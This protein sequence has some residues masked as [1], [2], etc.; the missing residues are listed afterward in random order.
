MVVRFDGEGLEPALVKMARRM[1]MPVV[2]VD[3]GVFEPVHES[4]HLAILVGQKDEMK[5]VGHEAIAKE[6]NG[7][8]FVGIAQSF[9]ESLV[10][11]VLEEN[12]SAHIATVDHVIT[13][14]AYIRPS[15]ARHGS[16]V[17]GRPEDFKRKDECPLFFSFLARTS[18]RR[19]EKRYASERGGDR[20][21]R[22]R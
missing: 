14:A 21:V 20:R 11:A 19:L 15:R 3:V 6:R 5:M 8:L 16:T 2:A 1:V 22:A 18:P 13:E 10:V 4:T 17:T 7:N 12:L 9:Q